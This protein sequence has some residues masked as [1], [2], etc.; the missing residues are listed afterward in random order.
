MVGIDHARKY[1]SASE[2]AE[3]ILGQFCF[4]FIA[5]DR[6]PFFVIALLVNDNFNLYVILVFMRLAILFILLFLAL[7]LVH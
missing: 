2:Q 5:I 3:E 7:M 4:K 1:E 6:T